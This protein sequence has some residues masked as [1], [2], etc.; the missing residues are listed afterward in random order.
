[1]I[2][3]AVIVVFLLFAAL[4][5]YMQKKKWMKF[6]SEWNLNFDI[7][8][9]IMELVKENR[10]E[11]RELTLDAGIKASEKLN[12]IEENY[13]DIISQCNTLTERLLHVY[14]ENVNKT[15]K[16]VEVTI[17]RKTDKEN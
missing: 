15:F 7:I 2:I 11:T 1:M 4:T 16:N 5:L 8:N 14:Q 10:K 13:D 12:K 17:E 3:Y 6:Y 9:K